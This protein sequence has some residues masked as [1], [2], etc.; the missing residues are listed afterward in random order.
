MKT[1]TWIAMIFLVSAFCG[2]KKATPDQQTVQIPNGDFE[3]W[4]NRPDLYDWQTNS[5]PACDPPFL[6][7]IVQKVTD[8]HHGQYAAEFLYNNVYSSMANNKF[9]VPLHPS[10]LTGYI[11]SVIAS[12]DTATIHIDL[13]SGSNIVDSGNFNETSST[14]VYKKIEIP[15][16]QTSG[17]ADSASIKIT[18]GKKQGSQ[19]YV[20]DFL[21]LKGH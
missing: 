17:M 8:A 12:G 19:L 4:D 11:K 2:C 1:Q 10:S 16:S 18:G 9:A 13:F 15:I 14:P 20:D 5:C 21:L 3:L 7:Y 6:T